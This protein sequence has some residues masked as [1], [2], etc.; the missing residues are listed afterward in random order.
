MLISKLASSMLEII[1]FSLIPFIWWLA[2]A[3]KKEGFFKW[4]GLR[5]VD[6][7]KLKPTIIF[8]LVVTPVLIALGILSLLMVRGVETA[9]SEFSG[10]GAKGI[11]AALVYAVLNTSLPE[12]IL[13]RGFLLKRMQTKLGF[14]AAN[15]IQSVV[16]GLIHGVMLFAATGPIKAVMIIL[17]TAVTAFVMGWVNEKKAGGSIL[18][19][20]CIHAASNIASAFIALFSII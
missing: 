12:E 19:S 13:F 20:W 17:F 2:T 5:R 3:R 4:L 1:L 7:D 15:I 6:R 14:T 10:L 16:F 18:P 8:T 9:T 11:P